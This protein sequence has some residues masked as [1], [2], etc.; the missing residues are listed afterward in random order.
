[1]LNR[2]H[3]YVINPAKP[4]ETVNLQGAQDLVGF[5]TSPTV[6]GVIGGY[7]ASAGKSPGPPFVP[8]AAPPISAAPSATSVGAG[9][10]VT[11]TG[12][13]ADPEPGYPGLAG[14]PVIVRAAG[15][16]QLASG[17]LDAGDRFSISFVPP[18]SGSY[19]VATA[20]ISR[21]IEPAALPPFGDLLAPGAAAPFDRHARL[22]RRAARRHRPAGSPH[23]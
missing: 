6:Q 17:L 18:V 20:A 5:L 16:G 12:S 1:L 3:A 8:D 13:V 21:L 15:G 23:R 7:L 22:A 2:F 14:Q 11:V 9:S 19:E 10:Q 4:G